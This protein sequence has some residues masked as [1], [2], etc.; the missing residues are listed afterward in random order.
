MQPHVSAWQGHH[1]ASVRTF[2]KRIY[3]LLHLVQ[4]TGH[5]GPVFKA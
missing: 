5:K 2:V 4:N 1:Q 3:K